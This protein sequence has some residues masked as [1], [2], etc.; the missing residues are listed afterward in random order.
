MYEVKSATTIKDDHLL[1]VAFQ[2]TVLEENGI[3]LRNVFITHINPNYVRIGELSLRDL[4]IHENVTA[5]INH[6]VE[7]IPSNMHEALQI[8]KIKEE[9]QVLLHPGCQGC[10]FQKYCMRDIPKNSVFDIAGMQ[11]KKAIQY[12]HQGI[13]TFDQVKQYGKLNSA[14]L[15]Q[16]EHAHHSDLVIDKEHVEAFLKQLQYPICAIDF[17]TSSDL[18]PLFDGFKV[19][20]EYP[21]QYSLHILHRPYTKTIHKSFLGDG[22][23]EPTL[24]LTK[25]LLADIPQDAMLVAYH[26]TTEIRFL[27]KLAER[28]PQYQEPLLALCERFIDLMDVFKS[29]DVYHP[30][31]EGKYSI[32]T[33]LQALFPCDLDLAYHQL[34]EIHDGMEATLAWQKIVRKQ[35]IDVDTLCTNMI[36]YNHLDT[37]AIIKLIKKLYELMLK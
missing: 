28:N 30:S 14:Q 6:F 13:I 27:K 17:E 32:K 4:F 35:V 10:G 24:A 7:E 34:E 33:V 18:V 26:A 5:L 3:H 36:A 8:L 2:K 25:Q 37:L 15:V 16:V 21:F 19:N 12:Y 22:N 1:D 23:S 20:E 31:M 11:F 29:K 9:P